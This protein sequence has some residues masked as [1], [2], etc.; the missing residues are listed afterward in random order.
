MLFHLCVVSGKKTSTA[1]VV[2]RC[3]LIFLDIIET[4]FL[5]CYMIVLLYEK[6]Y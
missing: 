1:K 5:E 6:K 2:F 4:A 3:L